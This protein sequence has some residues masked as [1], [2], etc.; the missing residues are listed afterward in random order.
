VAVGTPVANRSTIVSA[1]LARLTL[2]QICSPQD[3]RQAVGVANR[4]IEEGRSF[5]NENRLEIVGRPI[6]CPEPRQLPPRLA[7]KGRIESWRP[8]A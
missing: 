6:S 4:T 3:V 7:L 1:D 8:S 2:Q 5:R